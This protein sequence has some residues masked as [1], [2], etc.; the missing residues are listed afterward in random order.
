MADST[1]DSENIQGLV[2]L[3]PDLPETERSE[4]TIGIGNVHIINPDY[5]N[6]ASPG[7]PIG[8]KVSIENTG[9]TGLK[10]TSKFVYLK[11]GT[12]NGDV[13]IAAKTL[14]V[15]DSTADPRI[16]TN[17][18][19]DT[20]GAGLTGMFAVALSAMTDAYYGWFWCGGPVPEWLVSGMGGNY[21]TDGTVAAGAMQVVN[22]TLDAIGFKLADSAA[23]PICGY[24]NAADAA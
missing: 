21:P 1:I 11:V 7:F 19:D 2:D 13:A 18:P 9:S 10:G 17:D 12:Q 3:W 5:H 20:A 6:V 22:Q 15:A 24:A 14:V 23:S 4:P 8:A 16:V